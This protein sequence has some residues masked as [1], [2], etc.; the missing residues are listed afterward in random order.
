MNNG[1]QIE[2]YSEHS[3]PRPNQRTP[4]K[5]LHLVSYALAAV[6][7]AAL[8]TASAATLYVSLES[9]NPVSPFAAWATAATN[10]QEVVGLAAWAAG[11]NATAQTEPELAIQSYAG[12]TVTGEIGKVYSIEYVPDIAQTNDPNVWRCLEY[13]QLPASPYLWADK[14]ATATGKRFYRAVAM[15]APTNTVFIQGLSGVSP[16]RRLASSSAIWMVVRL[17]SG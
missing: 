10:I 9:T 3:S 4:M 16:F 1:I 7:S 11:P 2:P 15:E 12:L 5:T 13:L 14:S 6:A 17:L 8:G